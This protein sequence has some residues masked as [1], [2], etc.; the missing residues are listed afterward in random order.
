MK[1]SAGMTK[2]IQTEQVVH[3][4]ATSEDNDN[5]NN[6]TSARREEWE[7]MRGMIISD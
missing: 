2:L 5:I 1:D 4:K 3:I 7:Y 6:I